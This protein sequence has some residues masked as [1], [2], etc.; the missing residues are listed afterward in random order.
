MEHHLKKPNY[1]YPLL[2]AIRYHVN[3][4]ALLVIATV[5]AL[6]MANSSMRDFYEYLWNMPVT[7]QVGRFNLFSHNGESLS[8]LNFINDALMVIFFFMVGLEIKREMLVGELSS[9]RKAMLPVITAIGG[10]AVPVLIFYVIM[11]GKAG[12]AG[13]AIPMAT[14]IAFSLGVLSAFGKRV[15]LG[16]KVLLTAFAVVDDIG[17]ILVI[18]LFYSSHLAIE[19]VVASF[20]VIALLLLA[21]KMNIRRKWVYV[22]GAVVLWYLFMQSGIHATIAG[23]IAA[24]TVPATPAQ[25]IGKYIQLIKENV[26]YIKENVKD[27]AVLEPKEINIL[28]NIESSSD[29]VISPLQSLED[30]LHGFVNYCILP[31]FAFANAGVSFLGGDSAPFGIL[32]VAIFFA[33]LVGKFIGIYLFTYGAIKLNITPMPL[34]MTWRNLAGISLLGGIGFT[35]SLFIATLSFG[36]QP[37][38]LHQAKLGIL[39]GS[40]AAGLIGYIVLN[41][42]LPTAEEVESQAE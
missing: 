8:L 16:L 25:K 30:N 28:K 6:V 33:L 20:G 2:K 38:L 5:V 17:G 12:E 9:M 29:K 11:R 39:L 27:G 40:I 19:Y 21:N 41:K 24:F 4:S 42:T 14:D 7:L 15:P 3:S 13:M 26:T 31:L 1:N 18:A 22:T 32:T 37:E 34:G 35:V 10:M 23:V 36:D